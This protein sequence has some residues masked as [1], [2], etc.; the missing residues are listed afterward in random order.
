MMGFDDEAGEGVVHNAYDIDKG[1]TH[2]HTQNSPSLLRR[3][4]NDVLMLDEQSTQ[5]A[6][7]ATVSEA[8]SQ[9]NR[10]EVYEQARTPWYDDEVLENKRFEKGSFLGHI[11]A[12]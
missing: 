4:Q 2:Q 1:N 10:V 7:A 5:Q 6:T 12:R 9:A 3:L 8:V 11:F